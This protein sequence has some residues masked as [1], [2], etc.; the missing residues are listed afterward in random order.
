MQ[1]MPD[2]VEEIKVKRNIEEREQAQSGKLFFF[3]DR[4]CEEI[5]R[6]ENQG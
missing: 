6:S 3:T 5:K 2:E 1:A 4:F